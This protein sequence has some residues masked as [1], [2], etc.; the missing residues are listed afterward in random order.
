MENFLIMLM[1]LMRK[2][3]TGF[4]LSTVQGMKNQSWK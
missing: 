4:D 2:K 3:A 1:D